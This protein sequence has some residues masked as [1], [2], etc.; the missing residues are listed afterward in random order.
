MG[1]KLFVCKITGVNISR[2]SGV[3]ERDTQYCDQKRG[4]SGQRGPTARLSRNGEDQ[5][6]ALSNA[7]LSPS[8][9][10]LAPNQTVHRASQKAAFSMMPLISP[11][12]I[13]VNP[14]VGQ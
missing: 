13:T 14:L 11:L 10:G 4:R 6:A 2:L 5:P 8:S 9:A 7:L 1:V 12:S 3:F